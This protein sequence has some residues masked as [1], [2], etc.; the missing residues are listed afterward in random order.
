MTSAHGPVGHLLGDPHHD[1]SALYAPAGAALGERVPV[2]VRVPAAGPERAVWL[3]TVRDGEPRLEQA[4]LDRVTEHE[5][6]Y[7]ADVLVH[8]PLTSYRFLLDEPGG[9]RWLNGRGVHERDVP[10]AA[11]FRLTVH[12]PSNHGA[13]YLK[14][15]VTKQG[16]DA[17][18]KALAW[19]D[20]ELIKTTGRYPTSSPYVTD[21]SVPRDRTGHHVVFT[22]WQASHL[23]QPYYQCSDVTFGGGTQTPAP[24][25]PA[26][27]TP[28]PTTP[29]PTTPAPTTPAPT[30][31]APTTPAPTTPGPT[32]GTGA[33]TATIAVQSTWSGGYQAT[34][35]VTAGSS[36][37]S[38][39]K[40]TVAG[41]TITQAWNGTASGSTIT[42][43][44]W[45]GSLAAGGTAS[46]G[47]LGSGSS[48]GLTAS[49][50]AA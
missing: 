39:W 17:R 15:Y 21:V 44:A 27:T 45:N 34:V 29:A 37:L 7:V 25:T 3:R 40:V 6:W 46:A 41:A 5:R 2:R 30:T 10:D 42:S 1:G 43:A 24:T 18:T 16:Y 38:G 12:D 33:C 26:P 35:N 32:A 23:D 28:A 50:A 11:D 22:I 8:N 13:D 4:R 14:I 49:C 19:S 20:L 48:T 36:A 47:F 9:Y 31:P